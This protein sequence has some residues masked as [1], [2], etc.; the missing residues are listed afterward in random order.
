VN[1]QESEYLKCD[2]AL[3]DSKMNVYLRSKEEAM[4]ELKSHMNIISWIC[5][6]GECSNKLW[7]FIHRI[8]EWGGIIMVLIV[9]LCVVCVLLI[10][11]PLV[12]IYRYNQFNHQYNTSKQRR[13]RV[14]ETITVD[15]NPPLKGEE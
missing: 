15:N 1:P 5:D 2:L 7:E 8:S 13:L 9:F 3:Y 4:D 10:C 12:S 6:K 11:G 14:A